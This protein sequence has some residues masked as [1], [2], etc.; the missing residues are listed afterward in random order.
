MLMKTHAKLKVSAS[1]T[2]FFEHAGVTLEC[3]GVFRDLFDEVD[4]SGESSSIQ[5][6]KSSVVA[7]ANASL[8]LQPCC[9]IL[10]N[11][12]VEIVLEILMMKRSVIFDF[13]DNDFDTN[14]LL[15]PF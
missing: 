14:G 9:V 12:P 7:M 15:T 5:A 4:D 1:S 3:S 10:P 11:I 6:F 13:T 2:A 8:G